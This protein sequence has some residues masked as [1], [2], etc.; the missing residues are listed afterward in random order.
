MQAT[1][2]ADTGWWSKFRPGKR[3][4]PYLKTKLKAKMTEA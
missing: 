2:E 4:R 1:R 3:A